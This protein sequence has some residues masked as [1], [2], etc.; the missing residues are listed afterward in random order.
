MFNSIS[1]LSVIAA[2]LFFA[3]VPILA[4][5]ISGQVLYLDSGQ[6]AFNILIKCDGTGVRSEQLTDRGGKFRF[7][8]SPG[9]Y[10]VAIHA[11]GYIAEERSVDLVDNNSSEYFF[12]R[13]KPD[14]AGT[15]PPNSNPAADPNVPPAAQK[16]FE[17]AE[18]ALANGKK[19]GIEEGVVHLERA[20]SIYPK[21]VQAL[22]RIG[23]AY[24]DLA[25][26]DKAEQA[27][28][29]TLEMDPK[30]V[31]ALFALGEIYLRQKK[32]EEAEKIL[33]QGLQIEDRSFQGHLTLARVYSDM[34]SKMKDQTQARPFLEKAYDQVNQALKLNPDI[35]QAHLIKGNLLLR[36]RRAADA[37]HEFEEYLRLDPKGPF[38]EQARATVEKIKKALESQPK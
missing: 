34:A 3:D 22:L 7:F 20:I 36:V 8:V 26:W 1:R 17:K 35:A 14:R 12:F 9:H 37:Q 5:Q 6:A 23:T 16:E 29:K 33:L 31:N 25:Q 11:P 38:A 30:A 21:F 4:Q 19:E 18:V 15:K 2:F 32:N 28:K 27:L 24:M 13:L 10:T